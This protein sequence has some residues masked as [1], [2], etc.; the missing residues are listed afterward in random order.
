ME[1]DIKIWMSDAGRM[2]YAVVLDGLEGDTM[3][4]DTP[5]AKVDMEILFERGRLWLW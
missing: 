5:A 3:E 4:C 1:T 2:F